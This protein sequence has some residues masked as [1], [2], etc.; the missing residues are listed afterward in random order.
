VEPVIPFALAVAA[1]T[2]AAGIAATLALRRLPTLRLQL[3][4]LVVLALALPMGAVLLSGAVMFEAGKDVGVLIVAAAASTAA[5]A[6]T[7]LLLRPILDRVD[8]LR[9][10][11]RSISGGDLGARAP[12]GGPAELA[13]LGSSFNE[14]AEH[15]QE[16][17]DARRELVVAASHD[18][19]TPI[20]A[21]RAMI[22]AL[23]DGLAEPD[24]YLPAM[25]VQVETLGRLVDDLFELARIDS[26]VLTLE[27][28]EARMEALVESCLRGMEAEA[29][30]RGIALEA[31]LEAGLPAVRCAPEHVRRALANLLVNA[32]RHTP[33]DGAVAVLVQAPA[34]SEVQVT[35][36]DSGE[37]LSQEALRRAFERFWRGERS[38]SEPGAGLGLA[39]AKGLVEAQGGRVWAENGP[40]G[41]ARVSFT[42][43]TSAA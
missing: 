15:L 1:G 41:G 42:L 7:W 32:L 22:E 19:R 14:M 12:E 35:V 24:H 18:L 34:G 25:R 43:P 23:E 27:L 33:E 3:V 6:A 8:R 9:R 16:L 2:L 5:L 37:G 4:A 10:A 17:F 28:R 26:G 39:I 20:S 31:R 36:Q 11:S 40:Q 38:R 13:Q 30:S 21:L 29:R